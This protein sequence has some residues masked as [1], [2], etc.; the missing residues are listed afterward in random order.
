[1]SDITFKVMKIDDLMP[2]EY[3]PRLDL[4]PGDPDYDNL[5]KS[6]EEFGFVQNVVYNQETGHIVGGHQRIK[7]LRDLGYDE[8]M[9]AV[10]EMDENKEKALNLGLNKIEG[11][12]DLPKLKLLMDD[13]QESGLDLDLTGFSEHEMDELYSWESDE[14]D[15]L[16]EPDEDNPYT[17]KIVIPTY[18]ITGE[19]PPLKSLVDTEITTIL[20][21]II[22]DHVDV[23]EEEKTFLLLAATRFLKFDYKKIAEYYAHSNI[24]MQEIMEKLALVIIDYNKAIEN[25]FVEFAHSILDQ[26]EAEEEDKENE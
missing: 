23:P 12:W 6:I 24:E 17:T 13:L 10:V 14:T 1:M 26:Q 15:E 3:N 5:K 2:A 20:S 19:K 7:V 8:L 18:E 4:Q 25:G 22:K 11:D 21:D 9:V 16:L